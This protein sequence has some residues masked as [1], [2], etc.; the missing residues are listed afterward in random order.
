MQED[1][2]WPI[3]SGSSRVLVSDL[4]Y[5]FGD[6]GYGALPSTGGIVKS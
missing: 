3:A 4:G 6:R 2:L 5:W 1:S